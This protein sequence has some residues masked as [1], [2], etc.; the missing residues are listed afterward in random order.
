MIISKLNI[1]EYIYECMFY[2]EMNNG[3]I[4]WWQRLST[5]VSEIVDWDIV[6]VDSSS[7]EFTKLGTRNINIADIPSYFDGININTTLSSIL[8]NNW[9]DPSTIILF[10]L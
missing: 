7:S 5:Y 3:G 1:N 10:H 6:S 8:M 2:N 9:I 4:N